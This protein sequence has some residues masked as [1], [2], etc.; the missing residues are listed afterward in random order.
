VSFVLYVDGFEEKL[1]G[2][3][4]V[5]RVLVTVGEWQMKRVEIIVQ[6]LH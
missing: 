4:I 1:C 3:Y 6:W 2:N 5:G